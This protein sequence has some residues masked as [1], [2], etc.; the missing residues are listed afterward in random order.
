L[1][2]C[3]DIGGVEEGIKP[4]EI[5]AGIHVSWSI[6]QQQFI[7]ISGITNQGHIKIHVNYHHGH[8]FCAINGISKTHFPT[9]C[10]NE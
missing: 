4:I 2:L 3:R 10:M 7:L 1:G 9:K 6:Q 5:P 8:K